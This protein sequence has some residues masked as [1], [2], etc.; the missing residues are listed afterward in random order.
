MGEMKS[1]SRLSWARKALKRRI[2]VDQMQFNL[3]LCTLDSHVALAELEVAKAE[4]RV[5]ELRY[6]KAAYILDTMRLSA[7]EASQNV[8]QSN[9]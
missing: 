5:Q 8:V 6:K 2:I 3:E 7:K 1:K 9:P 4:Q